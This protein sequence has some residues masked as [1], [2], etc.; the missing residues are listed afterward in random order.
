M[1]T[2]SDRLKAA[3]RAAGFGS[4]SQAAEA[5]GVPLATYQQH[6]NGIR[7]FP[8]GRAERYA[9][10]FHVKPEWLLYGRG[11]EP[12]G[13][14]GDLP[15]LRPVTRYV[16]VIGSVQAGLWAEIPDEEPETEEALPVVMQGFAGARLFALKIRGPSMD[17]YYPEGAMVIVC[18]A[19]EIGV[20]DGDHVVVRRRR[21]MLVETTLK[22]VVQDVDGI[23]LWPRS[24]D[25]KFQEPV[26][27]ASIRDADEGPEIIGV[28]VSSYMVRPI[29]H[30]PLIQ[31]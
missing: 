13:Q 7:G 2:P 9:R 24:T 18:P 17:R 11:D 28:V 31:I 12:A 1:N 6:E 25:P 30:R 14:A 21:G 5:M 27:L 3:R 26:R 29:Q 4:A 15:G 20:R 8:A 10:F 22:E 19:A 23:S 16:P